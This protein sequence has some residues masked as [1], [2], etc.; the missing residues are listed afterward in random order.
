MEHALP[1]FNFY[2][3]FTFTV[4][5]VK[6]RI[7]VTVSPL[8]VLNAANIKLSFCATVVREEYKILH[9]KIA[10]LSSKSKI[11]Q[12]LSVK[13]VISFNKRFQ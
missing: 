7:F 5:K 9:K 13:P 10:I 2:I 1:V 11:N 4:F 3:L 8:N 6:G 12:Y